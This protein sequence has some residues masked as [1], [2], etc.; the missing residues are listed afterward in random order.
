MNTYCSMRARCRRSA[1]VGAVQAGDAVEVAEIRVADD[2]G[3]FLKDAATNGWFCTRS[4]ANTVDQLNWN[5]AL[6]QPAMRQVA[7]TL[8]AKAQTKTSAERVAELDQLLAPLEEPTSARKA[9]TKITFAPEPAPAPEPEPESELRQ[10]GQ[11]DP[12]KLSSL[13]PSPRGREASTDW[14]VS[15]SGMEN[16]PDPELGSG[17]SYSG[18]PTV[19]GR[20]GCTPPSPCLSHRAMGS[21]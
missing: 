1:S 2:G 14:G 15:L 19:N 6:A 10:S 21:I 17:Y 18:P 13:A 3:T 16:I 8:F 12:D 20:G 4:W 7:Y 9:P 5:E 11:S